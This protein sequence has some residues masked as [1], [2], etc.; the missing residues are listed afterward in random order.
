MKKE[1]WRDWKRKTKI[2]E[3]AIKSIIKI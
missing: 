3:R 1:F 2:E